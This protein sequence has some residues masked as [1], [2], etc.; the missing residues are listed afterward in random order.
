MVDWWDVVSVLY[1]MPL[2]VSIS[3][4]LLRDLHIVCPNLE[5]L[6]FDVFQLEYPSKERQI[7][8]AGLGNTFHQLKKLR[9]IDLWLPFAFLDT[10]TSIQL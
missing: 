10:S 5:I 9:S 3:L 8:A 1:G 6:R 7:F 4:Q 2:N